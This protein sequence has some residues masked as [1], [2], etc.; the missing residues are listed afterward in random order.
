VIALSYRQRQ[1]VRLLAAGLDNTEIATRLRI[2][3]ATVKNHLL[4]A[5]QKTG[6]RNRVHLAVMHV[7][8]QVR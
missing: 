2:R 1:C 4:V 3:P 7:C 6:A 5:Y 8:G